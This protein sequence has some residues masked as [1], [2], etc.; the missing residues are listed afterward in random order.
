MKSARVDHDMGVSS[1]AE[2][3]QS[4]NKNLFS[5]HHPRIDV[6]LRLVAVTL[7]GRQ[8]AGTDVLC[9]SLAGHTLML[10]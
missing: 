10:K 1:V 4:P 8:T 7:L 9:R 3:I 2:R 5:G 6:R